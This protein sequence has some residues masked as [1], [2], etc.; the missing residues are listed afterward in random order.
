MLKNKKVRGLI[1]VLLSLILLSL[2]LYQVGFDEVLQT[3]ANIQWGW[4]ALAFALFLLN[5]VIRAYRWFILLHSLDSRPP[6]SRLL[7]LYF[8]G[9]FANNFIP[10]GFGGDVVKVVNLRQ[11]YGRGAEALSSVVMDRATGLVGSSIIAL[12]TIAWYALSNQTQRIALPTTLW[13]V[14]AL[15]SIGIPLGFMLIR[16]SDVPGFFEK[17]LP[18]VTGLPFYDKVERLINTVRRYPFPILLRSLFIS[19]PFTISLIFIQYFIARA[20]GAD[21]PL[22]VFPLFVPLIALLNL[23]PIA[24]NGLGV[25]EGVYLFLFVPVGVAP[26][27]AVAMS[28][29]F[30][31]LRVVTGLI[32][33]LLYALN[34]LLIFM[35]TPRA[36]KL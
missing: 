25:R 2:L 24:F 21:V 27:T 22:S 35:R 20:L 9:F 14:I 18:V 30:Y 7:Y 10:S 26:E 4:Y 32:G 28:L 34:S 16:W 5:V 31:F 17:R 6:F 15:I 33:G 23:L 13:A 12:V 8:L 3:F 29:A 1:Q 19:L 11:R 36:K